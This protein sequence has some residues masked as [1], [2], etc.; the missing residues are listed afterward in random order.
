VAKGQT[1]TVASIA[2][3][4]K[5]PSTSNATVAVTVSAGSKRV[6]TVSAN[7]TVKAIGSGKCTLTI[8][9]TGKKFTKKLLVKVS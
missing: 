4:N 7:K 1:L 3:T 9:V 5:L 8:S 6:C 2:S